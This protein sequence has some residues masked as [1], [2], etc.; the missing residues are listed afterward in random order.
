MNVFSFLFLFHSIPPIHTPIHSIPTH[1]PHIPTLI[2]RISTQ[3]LRILTRFPA[4]PPW[5][6]SFRSLIRNTGFYR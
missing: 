6:P 1:I 5:F 3:I 2:P 4:S